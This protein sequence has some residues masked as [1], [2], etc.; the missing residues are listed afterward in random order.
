MR[1]FERAGYRDIADKLAK[2]AEASDCE[3]DESSSSDEDSQV[4]Q[5]L[6]Y[7]SYKPPSFSQLSPAVPKSSGA[8]YVIVKGNVL[9]G[10][11]YLKFLYNHYA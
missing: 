5:P 7:P 4:P 2:L 11:N 1:I 3:T 9:K 8:Y 10:M 6:A